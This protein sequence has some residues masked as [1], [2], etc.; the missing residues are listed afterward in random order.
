MTPLG[1]ADLLLSPDLLDGSQAISFLASS[2]KAL[3]DNDFQVPL[4]VLLDKEIETD[5]LREESLREKLKEKLER[6]S[7]Y[8]L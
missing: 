8:A 2:G 1:K 4:S 7:F 5:S 3:I 6:E